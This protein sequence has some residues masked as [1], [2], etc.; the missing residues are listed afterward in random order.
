MVEI[1][2]LTNIYESVSDTLDGKN[3]EQKMLA[4]GSA[5]NRAP[6]VIHVREHRIPNTYCCH[7]QLLQNHNEET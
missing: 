2:K 6:Q 3:L 5:V 1:G 4:I 7:P